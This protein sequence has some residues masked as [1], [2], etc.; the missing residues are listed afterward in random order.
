MASGSNVD[1]DSGFEPQL[2]KA[3]PLRH[4]GRVLASVVILVLLALFAYGAATNDAYDWSTYGKYVFDQR[5]SRAALVTLELTVVAMAIGLVLGV[6]MAVMR[7]SPNPVLKGVA[8]GYLWIFRGTP[9]YVQLVFWGLITTI[10]NHIDLGVPFVHQ[11]AHIDVRN[12]FSLFFFACIGLGLNEGAYMAE[13]VRAGIGSVDE[14]QTE[15]ASALG[16]SWIKTMRRIVLPQAMRVIIPP[17]GNELIG[18]LKTT[19]LVVAIPLT[20]DLY[21]QARAISTANFKPIPLL[22]VAST[23]YLAV[24]SVLM[25]GQYFLEK[26]YARGATRKMSNRQLRA[27]ALAEAGTRGA[28][29]IR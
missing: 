6:L 17:T 1:E 19:S 29:P 24:T 5:M 26:R 22:L 13:I 12:A 18:M 3:K 15:A 20:T 14:G 10:Y 25:V 2:I 11:F 9:V 21:S 23:W 28:G 27:L 16:M 7:L 8:W 4:P